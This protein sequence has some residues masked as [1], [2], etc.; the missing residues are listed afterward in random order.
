MALLKARM[1]LFSATSLIFRE[2]KG[3]KTTKNKTNKQTKQTNNNNNKNRH[4]G[5]QENHMAF[6]TRGGGQFRSRGEMRKRC[7]AKLLLRGQ[8]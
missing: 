2:R 6:G 4:R 7:D 5:V 8:P 3:Q 1:P